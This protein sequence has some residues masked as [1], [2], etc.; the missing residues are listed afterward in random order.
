MIGSALFTGWLFLMRSYF[1]WWP[2]HPA[3]YALSMAF[4]VDYFWSCLMISSLLK[5]LVMRWG[6]LGTYRRLLPMVFGVI[7]GEYMVGAFWSVISVV[8]R[9]TTYDF[10]PG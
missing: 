9:V 1:A 4:G 5:W 3:G 6:G 7:I 10:A 8:L 2:F